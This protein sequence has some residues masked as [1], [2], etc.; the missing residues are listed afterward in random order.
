M[1]F[2]IHP[3]QHRPLCRSEDTGRRNLQP[4]FRQLKGQTAP[5]VGGGLTYLFWV[6]LAQFQKPSF[7]SRIVCI[8]VGCLLCFGKID[9]GFPLHICQLHRHHR[10]GTWLGGVSA[11]G[12]FSLSSRHC[13]RVSRS[14]CLG[15]VLFGMPSIW[16]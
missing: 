15:G 1:L 9:H 11:P 16:L 13:R 2:A 6:G 12:S 10:T 7:P 3:V 14:D 4:L 8:Y 5:I